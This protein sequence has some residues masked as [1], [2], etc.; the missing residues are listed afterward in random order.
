[1]AAE[2]AFD[3]EERLINYSVR[4]IR[5]SEAL[6]DTKAGRHVASQILRSG[7]SPAPNYGEAQSAE[8]KADFVHKV[9]IA[10]KELKETRIWLKVISKAKMVKSVTALDSLLQETEELIAIL[11]TSAQTARRRNPDSN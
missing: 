3:L 7:T 10:L 8:S 1:M 2:R 11:F 4:I 5:L 9:K 6:P